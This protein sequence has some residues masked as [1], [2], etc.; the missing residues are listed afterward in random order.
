[1][2]VGVHEHWERVLGV[3]KANQLLHLLKE[4]NAKLER[5]RLAAGAEP[6]HPAP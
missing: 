4:L 3:R 5:E 1:V 6:S 2:A